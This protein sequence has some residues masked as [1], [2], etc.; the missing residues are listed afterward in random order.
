M[1]AISLATAEAAAELRRINETMV[2]E[3]P[4]L[5]TDRFDEEHPIYD[6][7]DCPPCRSSEAGAF[8]ES[9]GRSWRR[10]GDT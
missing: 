8:R 3:A 10:S 4:A 7:D 6:Q 2:K 1:I 5:D 9:E